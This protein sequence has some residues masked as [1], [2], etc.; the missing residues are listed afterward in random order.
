M[1]QAKNFWHQA[2]NF[3]APPPRASIRKLFKM[4]LIFFQ[5][6]G[7]DKNHFSTIIDR[8]QEQN[9]FLVIKQ[10][11]IRISYIYK[12]RVVNIKEHL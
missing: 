10:Y 8:K 4:R 9:I 3:S 5:I 7:C 12:G 6:R 2:K 11:L 1:H